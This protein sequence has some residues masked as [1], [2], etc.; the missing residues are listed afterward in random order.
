VIRLN[1]PCGR[2]GLELGVTPAT[3]VTPGALIGQVL[4]R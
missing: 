4:A 1:F 2:A 3:E